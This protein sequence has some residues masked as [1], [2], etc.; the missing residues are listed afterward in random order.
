MGLAG[1]ELFYIIIVALVIYGVYRLVK[2]G[3]KG[4]RH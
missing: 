2:R 4:V 3:N 1:P